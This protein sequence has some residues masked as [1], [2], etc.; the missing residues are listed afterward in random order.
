QPP[1]HYPGGAAARHTSR[2]LRVEH[3]EVRQYL[4]RL[5][6]TRARRRC[7][8]RTYQTQRHRADVRARRG[9]LVGERPG[10]DVMKLAWLFPGQGTQQVGMGRA[11]YEASSAAKKVFESADLALGWSLTRLCFEG[12]EAELVLT[13]NAQPAILTTSIAALE[14]LREAWP[15]LPL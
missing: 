10:E 3:R 11:L 14:A 15:E 2:A 13:A 5:D 7:S 6:P 9:D 12:P 4:E 1:D 8:R